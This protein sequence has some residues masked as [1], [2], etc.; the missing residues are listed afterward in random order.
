MGGGQSTDAAGPSED[1]HKKYW[2][3]KNKV[4]L[5]YS[6]MGGVGG[7]T[8]YHTSVVVNGDEWFFDDGGVMSSGNLASHMAIAAQA[9]EQSGPP[10]K[11]PVNYANN[12]STELSAGGN[13]PTSSNSQ[14]GVDPKSINLA[15]FGTKLVPMGYSRH[16]GSDLKRQLEAI[17]QSGSYDL[18]RK[19]CNS[20]S[21]CALFVLLGK[22]IPKQFRTMEEMGKNYTSFL[23]NYKPNREADHFDSDKVCKQNDPRAM[24]EGA[25]QGYTLNGRPAGGVGAG[26]GP[27]GQP[28]PDGGAAPPTQL[29]PAELRQKRLAAL[30][31]R[32]QQQESQQ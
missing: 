23:P 31:K 14:R 11:G 21:D 3:G 24:W 9:Q 26:A 4:Q 8:A 18:L 27:G 1:D 28:G 15:T 22:R 25:G 7:F 32:S 16:T 20:F 17:F 19:N 6:P 13:A 29:S 5:A 10:Q 12:A 2:E 30:E